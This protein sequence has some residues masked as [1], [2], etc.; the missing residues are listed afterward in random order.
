MPYCTLHFSHLDITYIHIE[1]RQ[2][3]TGGKK[4]LCIS[5]EGTLIEEGITKV[6]KVTADYVR[7]FFISLIGFQSLL[8]NRQ[9]KP[10]KP[11]L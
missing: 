3:S 1:K 10:T 4:V 5:A 6:K 9:D 8:L 2:F 11:P 7:Y